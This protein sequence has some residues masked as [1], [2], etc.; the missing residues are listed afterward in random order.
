[1]SLLLALA[2]Q[3]PTL[4]RRRGEVVFRRGA[5]LGAISGDDWLRTRVRGRAPRPYRVELRR[6]PAG[7]EPSCS[8][9][10]FG[11]QGI[12]KHVWASLLWAEGTG[13]AEQ[14]AGALRL[15]GLAD[16]PPPPPARDVAPQALEQ[17]EEARQRV[18]QEEQPESDE[19][20]L[21]GDWRE[22]LGAA[23][24]A[25][26]RPQVDVW[27]EANDAARLLYVVDEGSASVLRLE[28]L[29]APLRRDG[30][31]GKRHNAQVAL[32]DL[33]RDARLELADRRVLALLLAQRGLLGAADAAQ[34][35]ELHRD[36]L[37]TL[38]PLLCATGR[39]FFGRSLQPLLLDAKE[40]WQPRLRVRRR[41][42]RGAGE[43]VL[44]GWLERDGERLSPTPPLLLVDGGWLIYD[45]RAMRYEDA[46][47]SFRWLRLLGVG[48]PLRVPASALDELFERVYGLD[49]P[50]SLQWP[51]DLA[52]ELS[53]PAPQPLLEILHVEA[54]EEGQRQPALLQ[55]RFGYGEHVVTADDPLT[56]LPGNKPRELLLRDRGAEL[57]AIDR[58]HE[59]G[60]R[61]AAR[62]VGVPGV[63]LEVAAPRLEDLMLTLVG[64]G[65]SVATAG[66]RYRPAG[67]LELVV[68]GSGIDWFE[69]EGVVAFEDQRA[70]LPALL[71][72]LAVGE[73][74]VRLADGS[75]GVLP[76]AWLRRYGLLL[77]AGT[78]SGTRLRYRP[79]QVALLDALLAD[80]EHRGNEAFQRA[81]AE[82]AQLRESPRAVE[83]PR[84]F[85]G[86]L[87][88]Y[89]REGLGWLLFLRRLGLGGCLADDMGLGK[90]VQTLALL[91]ALKNDRDGRTSP[92]LVVVPRSLVHNWAAEAA[93]FTPE[94][95]VHQHGGPKRELD[96]ELFARHDIVITTYG[97]LRR[98]APF[99]STITFEVVILDESQAVKNAS[100]Q[101]AKAARL[102]RG[103]LRLALS[104][105]PVEN[106]LSELWSLY[107]F[108]TPGLLGTST[109]FTRASAL[110]KQDDGAVGELARV[111]RPLLLRRTKEQV[112]SD[113]P[114]RLIQV[115]SCELRGKE[116]ARYDELREHYRRQLL[117]RRDGLGS[118][119]QILEAL[120]RLRQAACHPG[121]L[122]RSRADEPSAKI[123]QLLAHL[124]T[125]TADGHKALVFSQFTQ[126]LAIVRRRL[127]REG[128][129]YEYL[130]GRTRD[131]AER[132]ERF[133][134]DPD[135][136][137]FLISLK[138]GGFG[139]NLTAADYVF[140][141][142][143]WWNPAVEA[144]AIDRT[145][146]IGQ[147]RPVFA[148]RLIAE[149]TVEEKVLALQARKEQL[150]QA[151]FSGAANLLGDLTREDLEQLLT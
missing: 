135:C 84:G 91:Q 80:R 31:W 43:L 27:G 87:R 94:L 2:P 49:V 20:A 123:E 17:A 58:L 46:E 76:E 142:D 125:A 36:A 128:R 136:P 14:L 79:A 148:Y 25:A 138:A 66:R 64:E 21:T 9:P 4:V 61:P 95:S 93:R 78:V 114:P 107:A 73:R 53:H 108:L 118:R 96:A 44:D 75:F 89:Q 131:R 35:F 50:P 19:R 116:R 98:D 119:V 81:R 59:L 51:E 34:A 97:T 71:A 130:D 24:W 65:W 67:E 38:L 129:V 16:P 12:C 6:V 143:P 3:V 26:V 133:Q 122:D 111:L 54:G 8:C 70:D 60:A 113:L 55:L 41:E 56:A 141:L 68:E 72:A 146:R 90:T 104:G 132:V 117:E 134:T 101:S 18:W 1:M 57:Q 48:G 120:L 99:L 22:R 137:L 30:I 10:T 139:L 32:D 63:G 62:A 13:N 140:L 86:E 5:V 28:L 145:H 115:L 92:A 82:L 83:A 103:E 100:S 127:D 85:L 112:A 52:P 102:L 23:R 47:R 109:A 33:D 11:W 42:G 39:F 88:P 7:L 106:R 105:T 74:S 69:L 29:Q 126:L 150:A 144:Q 147:T 149:E 40:P 121:L 110:A 15:V 151:I 37:D 124:E 77:S 45:G